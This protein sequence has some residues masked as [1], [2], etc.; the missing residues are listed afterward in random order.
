MTSHGVPRSSTTVRTPQAIQADLLKIEAYNNLVSEVQALKSKHTYSPTSLSTTSSLLT[1]N[2]EFNTIWNFRRRI[3]LHLL[4]PT[5]SSSPISK[6]NDTSSSSINSDNDNDKLSLLSS[7]LNFLFPLLQKFPKCYWIWNY[8]V[9]I[10]QT[11]STNLPLQTALKLW[12]SE[13]GLVNKMLSRDSR[14]FHG[15][16]YRRY[17][18]QNIETLQRDINKETIKKEKEEGEEGVVGEEEEESL[19]EQEFAYTTTM[20]GKDLSNFSAWH[21]RSK[22]IPRVLSE[23]GATIEER[24]TF[25]DGELGEMQ[26]AVYTDPYDQSIQ[27]YNH[28]LLLE[29]CSSKQT[30]STTSPVF[31]LTNSQKSETLLRTLE[32]MRELLDEEPDCRLLLEEMIFVGS[33][34]RDLD[35]TEEEEDVDRDEV[36]RDMQSWLEKLMEVDPMRGGRWR[37]MQEKLM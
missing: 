24:R 27:L 7:E 25:L 12:K 16:G 8:R 13:M 36:K 30:T 17:I 18:V 14:N 5:S 11:A 26:T 9:F 35:E 6:D 15:W 4:L 10:L 34:L 19:V 28:W 3:V 29:S 33:L 22:L 21:N 31:S 23:R 32:W 2:P 20:Y 37:E 1:Q